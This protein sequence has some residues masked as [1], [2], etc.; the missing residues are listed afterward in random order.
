MVQVHDPYKD[1]WVDWKQTGVIVTPATITVTTT[2][3]NGQPVTCKIGDYSITTVFTNGK[4]LFSGIFTTG[5]ASITCMEFGKTVEV[6]A[7]SANFNVTLDESYN[8]YLIENGVVA[9]GAMLNPGSAPFVD[10]NGGEGFVEG[11]SVHFVLN[12]S[13]TNRGVKF[14][15]YKGTTTMGNAVLIKSDGTGTT[16]S[17]AYTSYTGGTEYSLGYDDINALVKK[18]GYDLSEATMVRVWF[19]IGNDTYGDPTAY[20][21]DLWLE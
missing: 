9:N 17:G 2:T 19:F 6:T 3:L 20:I 14:H 1:A 13:V 11:K 10:Y 15:F 16:E 8:Y 4:A 12:Q 18:S 21:K 7:L 5:T